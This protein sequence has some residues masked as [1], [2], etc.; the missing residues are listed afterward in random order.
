MP[1]T[2]DFEGFA[3]AHA[4]R[5]GRTAW[6][7]T[8]NHHA[9]EDLVQD[10]LTKLYVHWTRVTRTDDPV[11]YARATMLNT[12]ISGRRKRSS[13]ERPTADVPE[14]LHEADQNIRLDLLRSLDSLTAL[15]RT[16]LVLRFFEDMSPPDVGGQLGLTPGAVRT[17]TTRALARIRPL[18]SDDYAPAGRAQPAPSPI[19]PGR[20]DA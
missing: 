19:Q 1:T 15:D 2:H 20:S 9:A 10:T 18:L 6:L 7:L 5:L 4:Q 8:G 17:R 14:Q 16:I 13:T 3:H 11:R 12:F